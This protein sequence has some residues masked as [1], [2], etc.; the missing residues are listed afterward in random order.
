MSP[1]SAGRLKTL[2]EPTAAAV[3]SCRRVLDA[4]VED[5]P[6]E[7][8]LTCTRARVAA[9]AKALRRTGE[10]REKRAA[11]LLEVAERS[12]SAAGCGLGRVLVP[13]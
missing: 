1:R 13:A 9:A 11:A 3:A 4:E 10:R 5:V 12:E 6:D 2:A 8:A 7:T